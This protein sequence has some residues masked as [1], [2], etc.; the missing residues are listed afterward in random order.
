MKAAPLALT[1]DGSD[2]GMSG[3]EENSDGVTEFASRVFTNA[4]PFGPASLLMGVYPKE[5]MELVL[6]CDED[7]DVLNNVVHYENWKHSNMGKFYPKEI[8]CSH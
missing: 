7:T 6:K 5:T 4:F 2:A 1:V 3:D 8:V